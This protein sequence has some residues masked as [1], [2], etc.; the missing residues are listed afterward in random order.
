MTDEI[1]A[2]SKQVPAAGCTA[3]GAHAWALI[4]DKFPPNHTKITHFVCVA[5][6][7]GM[8]VAINTSDMRDRSKWTEVDNGDKGMQS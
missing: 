2:K 3:C 4:L 7:G 8:E 6:G 5:C 1:T